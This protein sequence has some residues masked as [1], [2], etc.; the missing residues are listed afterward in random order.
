MFFL[1]YLLTIQN[2]FPKG[3]KN[4][5]S[6]LHFN[7]H[8]GEYSQEFHYYPFAVKLDRCVGSCNTLNDLSNKVCVPN[9]TEDLNLSVFNMITGI[10]ESKTLTKHISCEC[11]CRFDGRKCN[12]NQWWN[13]NKCWCE[14]KKYNI[15]EKDYIWNPATCNC[16]NGKYLASIMDDSMITCDEVI[17]PYDEKIKTIPTSFN[18]KEVKLL[19]HKIV[20]FYL[21]FY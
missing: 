20:I 5:R 4:E 15:S 16:E 10:N 17:K 14:C 6:N 21:R 3:I 12:S 8:Y 19:K 13:N 18:E 7:L 9:K 11:K 2:V 1:K